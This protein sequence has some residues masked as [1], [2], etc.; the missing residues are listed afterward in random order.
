MDDD[1]TAASDELLLRPAPFLSSVMQIE[2]QWIDYNGHL[3]MAYYNVMFDRAID[4]LWLQARD[5]ARLHEGAPRLDLHRRMPC[6]LSARNP[7]RRSRAGLDP[8]GGRRREAA[9]YV[10]GTAP[11]QR[12]LAVRHVGEHD[13]SH[14]HDRAQDRA[15]SA[16]HPRPRSRPWPTPMPP[17]R[18]PRASAERSRCPRNERQSAAML[19]PGCGRGP[20]RPRPRPGTA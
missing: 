13:H 17:S 8:A 11:C 5:R 16:R 7:S 6:A 18:G 10:R 14:R 15:V 9:A 2:P 20:G 19:R 4:E 12:G 3:N 1:D